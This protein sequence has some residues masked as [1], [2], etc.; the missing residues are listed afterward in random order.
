MEDDF[1]ISS[2]CIRFESDLHSGELFCNLEG[3]TGHQEIESVLSGSSDQPGALDFGRLP[4]KR[5]T[6]RS[7][8]KLKLTILHPE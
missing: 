1:N 5:D 2:H 4:K 8:S 6:R 3:G 7:Y